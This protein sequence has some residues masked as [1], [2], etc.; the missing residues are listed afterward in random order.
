[1]PVTKEEEDKKM[2]GFVVIPAYK[3]EKKLIQIVDG[4]SQRDFKVVLV[5][6]GSGSEY[7]NVFKQAK[8]FK[9]LTH[10]DN[11]GK[12]AAL[13][14]AF[15]YIYDKFKDESFTVVTADA[16]GQHS[17]YDILKISLGTNMNRE[18]LT[19]GVRT[20]QKDS[21]IPLRSKFGNEM[22]KGVFHL[23]TGLKVSDTQTGLRGFHSRFLKWMISIKGDKYEYEMNMLMEWCRENREINEMKIKTI[24]EENNRASHFNTVKDSWR[25]YKE[26]A[27]FAAS[28]FTAFL[29]DYVIFT[30]IMFF[31]AG[32]VLANVTARIV[33]CIFNFTVNKKVVFKDDK[34]MAKSLVKYSIL[35]FAILIGNTVILQFCVGVLG[36]NPYV[37]KILSEASCFIFS[38]LGQKKLVFNVKKRRD[39]IKKEWRGATYV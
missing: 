22:T 12:G 10:S 5:D 8:P 38:W 17:V 3:P 31:T 26:I 37:S 36:I 20:F 11:K 13:K 19:I 23:I 7:E 27:K 2:K 16:D 32:P 34:S 4:L 29:L 9:L 18:K 25:I 6:D 35:A 21:N 28:S 39:D 33:S 30:I 1:M 15:K 24:Y 14:T